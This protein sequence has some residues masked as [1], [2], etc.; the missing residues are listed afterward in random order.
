MQIFTSILSHSLHMYL[1]PLMHSWAKMSRDD[2]HQQAFNTLKHAPVSPL[3]LITLQNM[4]P[5]CSPLMHQTFALVRSS[6]Q[7]EA[8][9]LNMPAEH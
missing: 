5:L 3:Y 6:P 2:T 1:D 9:W 4:T 7:P 8:Q